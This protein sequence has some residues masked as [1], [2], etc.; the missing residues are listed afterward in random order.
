[1]AYELL[2]TERRGAM[3]GILWLTLNRPEKLNALT[4]PL[5][6]ELLDVFQQVRKDRSVR[7]I[8]IT[9]AG[10]GFCAGMDFSGSGGPPAPETLDLEGQRLHFAT[11][12]RRTLPCAGWTCR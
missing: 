3:D 2:L 7:C 6:A 12:R 4:F 1:M 5:L 9:G 8:V 11:S 10:R